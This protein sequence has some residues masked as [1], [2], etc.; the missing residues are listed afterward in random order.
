MKKIFAIIITILMIII[1]FTVSSQEV[2][3]QEQE[4]CCLDTGTGQQCVQTTR[5]ECPGRFYTGP[6]YDCSNIP[7]CKPQTCIPKNKAEPCLRNKQAAE[8]RAMNGVPDPSPLESIPQC[9]PGCCIIAQ[10]VKA[11][12]LQFRQ[13]ENL[14]LALG[15]DLEMME[16][17]DDITSQIECKKV[18]S[19]T[20]LGCCVLG[21]G[22]CGYGPR[23]D[24]QEG[25]FVPLQGG[26]YCRDVADCAVETNFYSECGKLPG[27]ETDIYWYDSQGNQEEIW[28]DPGTDESG[29]CNY[30][31]ALCTKDILGN[32][33]CK[34]TT[35][36]IEGS[37]GSQEISDY[38]P[39]V[40]EAPTIEGTTLLSGTSICYNF[41]TQYGD[42][43]MQERSTGLQNQILHCSFGD[44]GIEGLGADRQKLCEMG[45]E[46]PAL[47]HGTVKENKWQNCSQCGA[48]KALFGFGNEVGDFLGPASFPF[49]TGRMWASWF[50]DYCNKEKCESGDYGDCIYHEDM[51]RVGLGT[52]V[53]SCDPIY[54]PG[55]AESKCTECGG[56]GDAI[57]N[58]CTRAECYSKGDCQFQE[59]GFGT[60][61]GTFA[62]FWPGL[63]LGDRI[64]LIIPECTFTTLV[65]CK[66]WGK[67][68]PAC[69]LPQNTNF[70]KCLAD[71]GKAYA[72]YAP[73]WIINGKLMGAAWNALSGKVTETVIDKATGAVFGSEGGEQQGGEQGGGS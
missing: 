56:G 31:H 69:W 73:L 5:T 19:P 43:R 23:R 60:K 26:Y 11:E 34:D 15:Y 12:V 8:C 62:W 22:E 18:G 37:L 44:I 27:T 33:Y 35:C 21:G 7:E 57:W 10:G 36:I 63:A 65:Y 52:P 3:A 54:P 1:L 50:G 59:A 39:K 41:Y 28:S 20:D 67:T 51:G 49:P 38:A 46:A 68:Q 55:L 30:P 47:I 2:Q 24:C 17:R 48:S 25:N 53:G 13:C 61:L 42:E 70:L 9:K 32:V 58:L 40:N 14:T 29:N 71:R 6:P 4:G 66:T 72:I 45:G 64:S 16:F